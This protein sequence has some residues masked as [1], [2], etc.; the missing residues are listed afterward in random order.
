MEY[1]LERQVVE[2]I[3]AGM[4]RDE[5]R[6]AALRNFGNPALLRD[7]TR[8]TW[9]WNNLEALVRDVRYSVRTLVRAPGFS[10]AAIVVMALGIGATVALFTVVHSVLLKPL[11]F[12]DPDRLMMLYESRI[13][14]DDHNIVA[15]GVYAEW[16]KNNQTFSDLAVTQDSLYALSG[17]GG[18][19]PER[20]TGENISWNLFSTLGVHPAFGRDFSGAD[21]TPSSNFTVI[22]SWSLWKRRFESNLGIIN[23]TIYIDAKPYTVIG[24]MPE[25]FAFH[26]DTQIWT[27]VYRDKPPKIMNMVDNHMF[28]VVGRLKPGVTAEQGAADLSLISRR[29]HEAHLDKPFVMDS[30]R[31]RPLLDH[32]V[33]DLKRPLYVLLAATGCVLLIACL[34]VGNLLV[35]RA[36]A[37]RRELAIRTALGGGWLRLRRERLIESLLLCA[38]GG[39]LG[40]VLAFAAVQWLLRARLDLPRAESVHIDAV[41]AAFTIGVVAVCSL[42]A[43]SIST[44]SSSDKHVLTILRESSRAQSGSQ[45]RTGLRRTLLAF[46]VGLTVVLLI[47]AGLLIKSYERLRSTDMGCATRNV[48]TMRIGLPGARYKTPGP[49]PVN[50]FHTMLERVRAVPGV[51]AAGLVTAVPGKGWWEDNGFTV[52]EHPPLPVGQANDALSRWADSGYFAAMGIPILRGHSFNDG[53]RLD[54]AN[55]II[56]SEGLAR[57]HF[58]G[59]EPLGKHLHTREK[60][61]TI[62]GIVGDTRHEIG[63]PPM[64]TKYFSLNEGSENYG[65]LVLRSSRDVEQLAVPVQRVIQEMDRDLPVAD[66]LTMNQ[67]LGQSMLDQ[68]FNTTLLV[69]FASLSLLLAAVGLFGVLSYIVAQRTGEIGIRMALGAPRAQ[70]MRRMLFD[71]LRPAIIGLALGLIAAMEASRLL[72][73]MLYETG[74]LDPMVFAVVSGTL[75]AVAAIACLLPAWR[76]SRIDPMQA[77]RT[78]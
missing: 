72:R 46:E 10:I 51:D 4:S 21:D 3:E 78:E 33:G 41:V 54:Q 69:G 76:A 19:L 35:A 39:A 71:G 40:L 12:Q 77:L 65:T 50:F 70:V 52:V 48:L 60:T 43:G 75:L 20:L 68:S 53:L 59:E 63:E 73:D 5:A 28:E 55:E 22:L 23:Q 67:L 6:A 45:S 17:S 47:G 38:G 8:V 14:S 61:Y 11:P 18:Q 66:V 49:A 26:P 16:K 27:T 32:M 30:A 42:F 64:E 29:I 15:P 25:W 13:N 2:N 36:A 9:G 1:H 44:F 24:V 62:I 31:I 56:I 7:Q 34:N 57:K 58:A 37:Q 74:N